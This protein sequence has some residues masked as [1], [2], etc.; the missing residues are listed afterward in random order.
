LKKVLTKLTDEYIAALRRSY[1]DEQQL[2]E[3]LYNK[4]AAF[5]DLQSWVE[6]YGKKQ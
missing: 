3:E 4:I 2:R 6:T 5:D 1:P